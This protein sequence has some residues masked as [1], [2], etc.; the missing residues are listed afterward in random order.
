M[1]EIKK[2]PIHDR[3]IE[4]IDQINN[5]LLANRPRMLESIFVD[6]HLP[7]LTGESQQVRMDYW[8]GAGKEYAVHP[9]SPVD[10][11]NEKGEVLFTVPPLFGRMDFYQRARANESFMDIVSVAMAQYKIQ[12]RL[13]ETYLMAEVERGFTTNAIDADQKAWIDI[14]KRY[15]KLGLILG[16]QLPDTSPQ[17]T[18]SSSTGD[19][20]F[21]D[22]YD[23]L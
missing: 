13:G 10:I 5:A 1:T 23:E 17:A 20:V 9:N 8:L 18:E 21:S 12:P 7:V 22:E 2:H 6:I 3:A 19:G 15:N 4:A 14:L 16:I 11:I